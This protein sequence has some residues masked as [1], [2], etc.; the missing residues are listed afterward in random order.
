MRSLQYGSHQMFWEC[1]R[2]RA[3]EEGD[4]IPQSGNFLDSLCRNCLA[5]SSVFHRSSRNTSSERVDIRWFEWHRMAEDYTSRDI[6]NAE[7]ILPA[8]SGLARAVSMSTNQQDYLAGLWRTCLL[9]GLI[10][11]RKEPQQVLGRRATYVA[12]SWSWASVRGAVRFPIYDWYL[13]R[14]LWK[15]RMADFEPLAEYVGYDSELKDRDVFG[16]LKRGAL[17]IRAPL[18]PVASVQ[19]RPTALPWTEFIIGQEPNRSAVAD[20]VA[21]LQL[22]P[23]RSV[24][25]D[26]GFDTPLDTYSGLYVTFLTRMPHVLDDG[27]LEHRFG[28]VVE[29]LDSG[30]YRR[31]GF[32]DGCF[33]ETHRAALLTWRRYFPE[34][35]RQRGAAKDPAQVEKDIA[36]GYAYLDEMEVRLTNSG[37]LD[38]LELLGFPR[39]KNQDEDMSD[40]EGTPNAL[41]LDPVKLTAIEFVLV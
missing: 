35:I 32:V 22:E 13:T 27:F 16:R 40:D 41:G 34:H 39:A 2:I 23:S 14:A 36:E 7:D 8:L 21:E 19:R 10:W 11:H 6:T 25:I 1:E 15:A 17:C 30:D 24:W 9:E 20:S 4:T 28:L 37:T 18:V 3:S 5:P 26:V 38:E 29:K 33:L 12:P 31:V